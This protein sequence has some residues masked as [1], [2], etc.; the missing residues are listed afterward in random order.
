M[1]ALSAANDEIR[2][3]AQEDGLTGLMNREALLARLDELT[4]QG[5]G[6]RP[7]T[8]F[9]LDLDR[10][11]N[12]ND[13]FGHHVGDGL[14]K[15]VA[16]RLQGA[17]RS[18]DM[19]AR[20]GGDEFAVVMP[21]V[22]S[23]G[24]G[25]K[26]AG[27]LLS[28]I[29]TPTEVMG[30]LLYP[31]TSV[32]GAEYPEQ[33]LTGQELL[34]T[35][36]ISL[37]AAKEDGRGTFVAYDPDLAQRIEDEER[38]A[39]ELRDALDRDEFRV[40]YQPKIGLMDGALAG[41]EALI[42]WE[43]PTRGRLGPD[44]FLGVAAERGL[45]PAISERVFQR[46][47]ADVSFWRREGTDPGPVSVNLHA[48]DLKSPERL[49]DRMEAM[50]HLG[51]GRRDIVLEVTEGCVVGRGTDQASKLIARLRKMGYDISLDDFGTGHAS[52]SHLKS[53]PVN[54]I[55]I[56]KSFVTGLGDSRPDAA[57]VAAIVALGRGLGL[58]IV[59][60]GVETEA[61][62]WRL[63][64]LGVGIGQGFLWSAALPADRFARF[65]RDRRARHVAR[66]DAG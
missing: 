11:K 34:L 49:I 61:H 6:G 28:A 65:A 8:L 62:R 41:S 16:Q 64:E 13:S 58:R 36:D 60:E 33:A 24:A 47:A 25:E 66:Q 20:L 53:L 55:K 54:E 56:D 57:I 45:A 26:W 31:G 2:R 12:V 22:A 9:M 52:L 21:G 1:D 18:G 7:F 38:M 40:E 43:H 30:Q 42:R 4:A 35:A 59:A 27:R 23:Q 14:I 29:N 51:L 5:H 19:V 17:V 39:A 63:I 44:L 46:V 48:V 50:A 3:L 10:F 32:G 15:V 37:N